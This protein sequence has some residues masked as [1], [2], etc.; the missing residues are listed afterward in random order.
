MFGASARRIDMLFPSEGFTYT[1]FLWDAF[2]VFLFIAWIYFLIA[3][4]SDLFRR[5]DISGLAKA[6]WVIALLLFSYIT[7]F[8]YMITQSRGMTERNAQR[9]SLF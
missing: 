3:I 8:A 2:T 5:D 1:N 7:I 4:T 6:L 9:R